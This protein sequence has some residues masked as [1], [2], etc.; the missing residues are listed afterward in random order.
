MA[1]VLA[2][3]PSRAR[4]S[5]LDFLAGWRTSLL[6]TAESWD[7][8]TSRSFGEVERYAAM[9]ADRLRRAAECLRDDGGPV[10]EPEGAP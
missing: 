2:P 5:Y 3:A 9:R 8:V 4:Q 7:L 1:R 6:R 10:V